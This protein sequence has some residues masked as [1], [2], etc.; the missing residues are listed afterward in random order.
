[1]KTFKQYLAENDLAMPDV[2]DMPGGPKDMPTDK[3]SRVQWLLTQAVEAFK[4]LKNVPAATG[5]MVN[6]LMDTLAG[7]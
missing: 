5:E 2:G 7:G 6:D 3:M 1:M 4:E